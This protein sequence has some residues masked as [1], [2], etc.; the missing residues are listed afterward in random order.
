VFKK[1]EK[2]V[3]YTGE[4][5]SEKKLE[6]R[7]GDFTAPYALQIGINGPIVDAALDRGIASLSNHKPL[8]R[9]NAEL[10]ESGFIKAKKPIL[11][12]AEIY[13]TYGDE[14]DPEAYQ[15]N[16]GARSWTK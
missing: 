15:F 1:G 6:D 2:I 8:S 4:K 3:K 9:A 5:I 10:S 13:V 7:Y 11:D 14:G 16:D 12:G